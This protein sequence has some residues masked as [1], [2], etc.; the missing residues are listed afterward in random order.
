MKAS[1]DD[2][3]GHILKQKPDFLRNI[4]QPFFIPSLDIIFRVSD[5]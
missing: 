5:I 2:N 3:L 1:K 4:N